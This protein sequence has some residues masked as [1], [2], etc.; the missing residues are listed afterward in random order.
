MFDEDRPKIKVKKDKIDITIEV[1]T[2]TLL[3]FSF[4]FIGLHYSDLPE[5][6][7]AHFG[8]NGEVNRYDEKKYDL[9]ASNNPISCLLGNV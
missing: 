8:L 7:P 5:Q 9:A 1:L 2:F 4:L 3:L 6:I